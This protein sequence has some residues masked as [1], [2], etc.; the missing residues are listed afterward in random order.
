MILE[1]DEA[2]M[3]DGKRLRVYIAM[4]E[5]QAGKAPAM[6]VFHGLGAHGQVEGARIMMEELTK[7]GFIVFSYDFR[8]V[9]SDHPETSGK[10]MNDAL[11]P[12]Y[13]SQVFDDPNHVL[14]FILKHPRVDRN[15]VHATGGSLG[16][17]IVLG[18]LLNDPRIKK[19][20]AMCAPYDYRDLI[21]KD[22]PRLFRLACWFRIKHFKEFLRVCRDVS[23]VSKIRPDP[24]VPYSARVYL[25][26]SEDD[27][28]VNF[29]TQFMKNKETMGIPDS[30]TL[31]FKDGG[32]TC[33]KYYM[34]IAHKIKEWLS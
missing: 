22:M 11:S 26:H 17:A 28:V 25:I 34:Q 15:N 2:V 27:N 33:Q 30:H 18:T 3:A 16:G 1:Q 20:F 8:G 9:D 12:E 5:A 24:D 13:F 6:I 32:H 19:I 29:K 10:T 7:S 21:E 4:N 31:I 23:P 14:D